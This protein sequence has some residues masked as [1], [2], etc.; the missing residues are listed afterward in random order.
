MRGRKPIPASLKRAN[1]GEPPESVAPTCPDH[2]QG[3]AR[4]EWDRLVPEL[5]KLGL[6]TQVDRAALA[7]YC[8][9]YARWAEAEAKVREGGVIIRTKSGNFIQNPYLGVANTALK[10]VQKFAAEF[11]L[12]PSSRAK[13]DARPAA[14]PGDALAAFMKLPQ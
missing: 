13:V 14:G 7:G 6:L 1:E 8:M 11:G 12:S 2:L 4:A 5:T 10:L 9:T 3:A